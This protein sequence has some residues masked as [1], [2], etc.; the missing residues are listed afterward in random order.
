[1]NNPEIAPHAPGLALGDIYYA[2]FRHKW[3]ILLCTATGLLVAAGIYRFYP[4]PAAS[5]AKLFIR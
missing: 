5:E 1:M 3:K 2:L 4:P